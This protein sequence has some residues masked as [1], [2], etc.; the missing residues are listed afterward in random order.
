MILAY[1]TETQFLPL[2]KE[3]S[4][5]P[6]QPHICQIGALLCDPAGLVLDHLD[7]I[8]K[9]DGWTIPAATT[10]IHGI[11][12]ER[13]MDEGIPEADALETFLALSRR[14]TERVAHNEQFDARIMR[15]A[16]HRF[17][18]EAAA[19]GWKGHHKV[20]C[21]ANATVALCKLPPTQKMLAAG[22]N[23]FKTPT[24]AES[25][26]HLFG[27]E[28]TYQHTA[29]GDA[30]SV[31]RILFKLRGIDVEP[32]PPVPATEAA[33]RAADTQPD[34]PTHT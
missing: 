29:L 31:R 17:R 25:Y 19:D 22:F 27:E 28:P 16:L 2:F 21:T 24:L 8:I 18:D 15:I 6:G 20:T 3:P 33:D 11:S 34:H 32:W 14:A 5:H 1:D 10:A 30:I 13:A 7:V 4:E 12:T 26:R 9:P 23:K